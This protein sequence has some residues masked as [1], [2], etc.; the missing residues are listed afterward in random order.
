MSG[1]GIVSAQNMGSVGVEACAEGP[2]GIELACASGSVRVLPLE[3][4]LIH[5]P[6]STLLTG[7]SMPLWVTG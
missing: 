2:R 7:K 4:V 3:G 1:S 5:A 6:T